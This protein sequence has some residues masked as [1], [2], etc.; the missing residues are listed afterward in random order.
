MRKGIYLLF[1]SVLFTT[2][3][4]MAQS[5]LGNWTV[6]D[7]KTG[8]KRAIIQISEAGTNLNG[9]VVTIYP[10]PNDTGVCK[11]CPG[12]FK[13][14][15]IKGLRVMWD[16][17]EQGN[18]EWDG[19]QALDPETGKIYRAKMTLK[20]DKLYVRGY[21]GLSLLGRTQVWTR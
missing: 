15:P 5:P 16:L 4:V 12:T 9:T 3:I 6:L 19:G 13:D 18:N 17:K 8:K 11:K 20:G 10:R 7:D 21:I 2:S 1:V 14:K